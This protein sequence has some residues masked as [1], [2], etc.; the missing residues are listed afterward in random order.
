MPI[1]RQAKFLDIQKSDPR[2]LLAINQGPQPEDD[3]LNFRLGM[4]YERYEKMLRDPHIES[5]MQ[6]RINSIL[7]R[8]IILESRA[9]NAPDDYKYQLV[10]KN[11]ASLLLS[12]L[13]YEQI[14]RDLI[15]SGKLIGFSALKMDYDLIETTDLDGEKI[16]LIL[17]Q[18]SFIPQY[19]ISFAYQRPQDRSI[20]MIT[21]K[22]IK[23]GLPLREQIAMAGEYEIRLLTRKSP[24]IGERVPRDRLLFYTY[25]SARSVPWGKGLGYPLWAWWMIK[26]EARNAWLLHSDRLGSPPVYGNYPFENKP[27]DFGPSNNFNPEIPEHDALVDQFESFLASMSPNGFGAFPQGFDVKLVEA[28]NSSSPDIHD[29]LI[30]ACDHQMSEAIL[31]EALYSEIA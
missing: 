4:C 9:Y 31:G 20:P 11:F 14:C 22:N 7:G 6:K 30:K 21:G 29:K 12:H 26:N 17:P 1:T 23:V 8:R 15:Y 13:N 18:F 24:M 10:T 25:G 28:I 2:F 16:E 5:R 27:V 3:Y 19:R